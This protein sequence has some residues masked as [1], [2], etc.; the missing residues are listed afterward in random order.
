MR[1]SLVLGTSLAVVLNMLVAASY[2]VPTRAGPAVSPPHVAQGFEQ[3]PF[4]AG[5][6]TPSARRQVHTPAELPASH[7][8]P[9]SLL[10][11][12]IA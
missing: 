6:S 3:Q 4:S 11:G 8:I 7:P 1:K 10:D 9:I 5:H 2:P 12:I